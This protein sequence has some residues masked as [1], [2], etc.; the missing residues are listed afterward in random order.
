MKRHR[1]AAEES[2]ESIRAHEGS[3]VETIARTLAE[4][5][6]AGGAQG[7]AYRDVR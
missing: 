3:V 7:V 4:S 5:R 1:I 6:T 2:V